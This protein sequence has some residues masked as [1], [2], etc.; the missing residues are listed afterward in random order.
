MKLYHGSNIIVE[1]PKI[2]DSNRALDFGAG[3]YVTSDL[4]QAIKWAKIVARR[5]RE[6]MPVVS[7]YEISEK[8]MADFNILKFSIPDAD[9]LHYIS[10]NRKNMYYGEIYDVVFGPVANDNTMSVLNLFLSG[11]LNEEETVKR[12]LPQKL[13]D[14]YAFKTNQAVRMLQFVEEMICK[15]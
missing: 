14:Q 13:K 10:E 1:H 9:W 4:E 5:R 8:V 7:A 15:K 2:I 12:L 11:F 3:F 6:G